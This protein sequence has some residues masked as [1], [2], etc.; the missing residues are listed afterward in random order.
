MINTIKIKRHVRFNTTLGE[1][2]I[3]SRK[4]KIFCKEKHFRCKE[5][6]NSWE[7]DSVFHVFIRKKKKKKKKKKLLNWTET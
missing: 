7:H 6:V 2:N 4:W 1:K 3:G 5:R